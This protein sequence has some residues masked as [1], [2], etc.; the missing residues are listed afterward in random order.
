MIN[1][2]RLKE[3]LNYDSDT[4]FFTWKLKLSNRIKIGSRAGSARPLGYREIGIDN[5]NYL[6]HR[7]VWL[8]VHGNFPPFELDHRDG[9]PSNNIVSNLRLCG[10]SGQS[11]NTRISK[12]NKCGIKGVCYRT[13]RDKWR[14][15]IFINNRQTHLGYFDT[16]EEAAKA[17]RD[18][19][20]KHFGE[21]SNHG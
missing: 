10:R 9:N 3:V 2:K 15:N 16:K 17:Y 19:A 18:A 5:N 4:G 12:N 6:E 1:Q 7:L 8:F 21:F 11:K 20:D 13:D 14:A